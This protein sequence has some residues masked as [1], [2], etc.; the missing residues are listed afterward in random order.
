M[1]GRYVNQP[2]PELKGSSVTVKATQDKVE[3]MHKDAERTFSPALAKLMKVCP[4]ASLV[5]SRHVQESTS[6]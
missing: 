3:E 6:R 2:E 1:F 5:R 4:A